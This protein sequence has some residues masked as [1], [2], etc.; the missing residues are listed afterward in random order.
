MGKTHRFARQVPC[1]APEDL[2]EPKFPIEQRGNRE[3][4]LYFLAEVLVGFL[5]RKCTHGRVSR[6]NSAPTE[7]L[8]EFCR[9]T[10]SCVPGLTLK[11]TEKVH[12]H[13]VL[14]GFPTWK[15]W[16]FRA[17][18]NLIGCRYIRIDQYSNIH[19]IAKSI[20]TPAFTHT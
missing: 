10:R 7:F 17:S 3:H 4:V 5:G 12:D 14:S 1:E 19:Y 6:Q 15:F 18:S 8:A 11:K 9:E 2:G 20:G 16:N 13:S